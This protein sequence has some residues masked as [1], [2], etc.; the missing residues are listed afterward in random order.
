M[1]IVRGTPKDDVSKGIG[2][3]QIIDN[4]GSGGKLLLKQ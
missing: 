1:A 4:P 2:E 3:G